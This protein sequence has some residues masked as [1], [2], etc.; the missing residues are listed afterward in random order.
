MYIYM[1]LTSMDMPCSNDDHVTTSCSS[2]YMNFTWFKKIKKNL[3]VFFVFWLLHAF[4]S[5]LARIYIVV[6]GRCDGN[7]I[8]LLSVCLSRGSA[9]L[10][11]DLTNI[12]HLLTFHA[13][14]WVAFFFF[15]IVLFST[16]C[17]ELSEMVCFHDLSRST[18]KCMV[19]G[20][21]TKSS[22]YYTSDENGHYWNA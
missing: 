17:D 13:V 20:D 2:Q 22:I 19:F 15:F 11:L 10:D 7:I 21:A 4:C 12:P 16:G 14:C 8:K 1:L 9:F 6:V 3:F 18:T 5:W